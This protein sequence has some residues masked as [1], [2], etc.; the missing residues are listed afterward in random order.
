MLNDVLAVDRLPIPPMVEAVAFWTAI[1][2]PFLYVPLLF[3][4]LDT[5]VQQV[6]FLVLIG[7]NV[8]MVV[9]GHRHHV[10]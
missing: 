4:G 5:T 9:L 3:I 10:D 7:L 1:V 2:L 6:L 8:V